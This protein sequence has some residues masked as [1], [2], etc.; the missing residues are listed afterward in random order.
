MKVII[1]KKRDDMQHEV[2]E[3]Q[4]EWF[5]RKPYGLGEKDDMRS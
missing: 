3:K 2:T 5:R 1:N 4:K